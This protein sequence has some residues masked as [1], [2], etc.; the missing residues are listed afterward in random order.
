MGPELVVMDQLNDLVRDEGRRDRRAAEYRQVGHQRRSEEE[1]RCSQHEGPRRSKRLGQCRGIEDPQATEYVAA[2]PIDGGMAARDKP[3]EITGDG[4]PWPLALSQGQV[5]GG[6]AVKGGEGEH[7]IRPKR[8][9]AS[10]ARTSD[11]G[12]QPCPRVLTPGHKVVGGHGVR[13]AP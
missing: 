5:S 2:L 9:Q 4:S 1:H 6:S 12:F 3:V 13:L 11:E 10:S 8:A 7:L